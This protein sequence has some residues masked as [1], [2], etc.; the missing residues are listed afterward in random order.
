MVMANIVN[1]PKYSRLEVER[2]FLVAPAQRPDVSML[3]YRTITDRYVADSCLRLRS[4]RASDGA[5]VEYRFCKKYARDAPSMGPIVNMMLTAREYE[6]LLA[7]PARQLR[8]RRYYVEYAGVRFALD[9]FL[10]ALDGLVLC[11]VETES[12]ESIKAV[13]PPNWAALEV[14]DDL[15]F[16]GGSLSALSSSEL[17]ARV[18]AL[19]A[20]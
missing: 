10:D 18:S 8:K 6:I 19:V 17:N 4:V 13:Q 11:E 20:H 16:T 14:T 12:E 3:P 1:I 9:V 15:F 7:L 5:H 2:R